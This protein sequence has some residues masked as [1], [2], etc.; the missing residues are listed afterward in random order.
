[1][2]ILERRGFSESAVPS[3][4]LLGSGEQPWPHERSP[5]GQVG[6]YDSLFLKI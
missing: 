2:P 3:G 5:Q 6:R 4:F 1:M